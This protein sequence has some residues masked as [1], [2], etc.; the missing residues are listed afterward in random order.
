MMGY[1]L[2]KYWFPL[3]LMRPRQILFILSSL[4]IVASFP[5]W[6]HCTPRLSCPSYLL[7]ALP[8]TSPACC[9]PFV[10]VA[11]PQYW[12][13]LLRLEMQSH[14]HLGF[15]DFIYA[16]SFSPF[17]D[18]YSMGITPSLLYFASTSFHLCFLGFLSWLIS[19][20]GSALLLS[21]PRDSPLPPNHYHISNHPCQ[22][23]YSLLPSG[24]WEGKGLTWPAGSGIRSALLPI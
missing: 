19:Y 15:A 23:T 22:Y 21:Q 5:S 8:H 24:I 9:S 18:L 20:L 14:L 10:R 6:V 13:H 4:P 2:M 17:P 16:L 1:S 3:P 7:C 11:L 12:H